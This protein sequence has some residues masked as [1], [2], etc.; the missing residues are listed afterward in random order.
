MIIRGGGWERAW[1]FRV[2][3]DFEEFRSFKLTF[4]DSFL[5]KSSQGPHDL[6]H[7]WESYKSY[8]SCM[9]KRWS[10]SNM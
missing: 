6:A 10:R 4:K 8:K 3:Q 9:H 7:G 5:H 1:R 2:M